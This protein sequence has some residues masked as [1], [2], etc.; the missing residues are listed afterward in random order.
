MKTLMYSV[1]NDSVVMISPVMLQRMELFFR[2]CSSSNRVANNDTNTPFYFP[3]IASK[4]KPFYSRRDWVSYNDVVDCK[5]TDGVGFNHIMVSEEKK[6]GKNRETQKRS[7]CGDGGKTTRRS[8]I[9]LHEFYFYF[10]F[11]LFFWQ[12]TLF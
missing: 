1:M 6:K 2:G 3:F 7:L 10:L 11:L 9:W 4:A 8:T 5:V 12:L